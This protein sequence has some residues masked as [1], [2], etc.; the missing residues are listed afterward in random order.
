[1][2]IGIEKYDLKNNIR[3]KGK[4]FSGLMKAH[5][6]YSLLQIDL[7][8]DEEII[9]YVIDNNLRCFMIGNSMKD[10]K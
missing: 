2:K 3:I 5:S 4:E 8:E 9:I 10:C 7:K 1:M 6:Y